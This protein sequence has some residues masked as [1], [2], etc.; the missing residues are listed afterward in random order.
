MR[1]P[2]VFLFALALS[3]LGAPV[4]GAET[5]LVNSG[6]F[7]GGPSQ[8]VVCDG[9][10]L[11]D[12]SG[13]ISFAFGIGTS[14]PG[15]F[16]LP[17]GTVYTDV[18][19]GGTYLGD[20]M[21]EYVGRSFSGRFTTT[22]SL[23]LACDGGCA[24]TDDGGMTTLGVAVPSPSPTPS[25]TPT[26]VATP[27]PAVCGNGIVEADEECDAGAANG[28]PD[29][30]CSATCEVQ[31]AGTACADDGDLC[32]ADTCDGFGSCV[33]VPEPA[34]SCALAGPHGAFLQIV[35]NPRAHVTFKW[36]KG[37]A[38]SEGEFAAPAA[39]TVYQLCVYD[40]AGDFPNVMYSGAPR[41]ACGRAYWSSSP[42]GWTFRDLK[43]G[44][45]GITGVLLRSGV[46]GRARVQMSAGGI[47]LALGPFPLQAS[48]GVVAQVRTSA[49]ACWGATFSTGITRNDPTR[50][51]AKSD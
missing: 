23:R 1:R 24:W 40:Q 11:A 46:P 6:H 51:V 25:A 19:W 48:P 41:A 44:P 28:T 18:T 34:T 30:C 8:R 45:D 9:V 4:A 50:F 31:A 14:A 43:G 47:P 2:V 17:D 32:T 16:T 42:S 35:D 12:G 13:A 49:G 3:V 36:N 5:Q 29:S 15:T 22:Q 20:S 26:S 10:P 33:H 7:C 21:Y 27:V 38:V 37:P 39:G